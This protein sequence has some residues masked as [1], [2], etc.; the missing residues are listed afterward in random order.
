MLHQTDYAPE[1]SG[2]TDSL[3]RYYTKREISNQLVQQMAKIRPRRLLDLGAGSGHLSHAAINQ[4]NVENLL[5]VDIDRDA[6]SFLKSAFHNI[7]QIDHNHIEADALDCRLPTLIQNAQ[8]IDAAVCNPPFIVKKWRKG[9]GEILEDVGLAPTS[10]MLSTVD[11][12][13]IF[14]AQNLRLLKTNGTLGIIV[15]DTLVSSARHYEFRKQ[16]LR[17]YTIVKCVRLP[18]RSFHRTD[19]LAHI[20]VIS[21]STPNNRPIVVAALETDSSS[22]KTLCVDQDRAALRLDYF[23]HSA[24]LQVCRAKSAS[25]QLSDICKTIQR[26]S[27]TSAAVKRADFPV[28]HTRDLSIKDMGS[29]RDFSGYSSDANSLFNGKSVIRAKAGD[30]LIARVGRN[31]AT[32]V[33]GVKAGNPALSD[34]LYR[35]E[36]PRALRR[37]ILAQLSSDR[38]RKWIESKAYGVSAQ[39]LPKRELEHFPVLRATKASEKKSP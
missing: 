36:V 21:K 33:V 20:L 16:L 9:F 37:T 10:V 15:P 13:L 5:T 35:I 39:Q 22:M 19:A 8:P 24:E 11:A 14:L 30:I 32:K 3:G 38:G 25:L 2:T 7:R 29:W 28:L 12:A 6:S 23:F 34:C 18:R 27:L 31:L 4:W 26:G 17:K 1:H